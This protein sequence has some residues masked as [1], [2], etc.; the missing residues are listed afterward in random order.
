MENSYLATIFIPSAIWFFLFH[1]FLM[2]RTT[3]IYHWINSKFK[4]S[5]K[6]PQKVMSYYKK[7]LIW[8]GPNLSSI[9]ELIENESKNPT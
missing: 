1:F 9:S 2:I 6:N 7:I 3:K 8:E 4:K 5:R